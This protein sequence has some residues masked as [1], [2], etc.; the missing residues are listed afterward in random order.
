M[1]NLKVRH[2]LKDLKKKNIFGRYKRF[3]RTIEYQ[4]RGLPPVGV[5]Y[6][7][8]KRKKKKLMANSEEK[9]EPSCQK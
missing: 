7:K 8:K 4:K 5:K 9:G 1:F 2:L 6:N 3:V